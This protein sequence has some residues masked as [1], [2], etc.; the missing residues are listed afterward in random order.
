M[1]VFEVTLVSLPSP[2]VF[3]QS[4]VTLSP[5]QSGARVDLA[6]LPNFKSETVK[7]YISSFFLKDENKLKKRSK[8]GRPW[9]TWPRVPF[10]MS[11]TSEEKCGD[12]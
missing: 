3:S 7:L 5:F 1:L 12:S 10:R 9:L 2:T 6:D 8:S 11:H 4:L